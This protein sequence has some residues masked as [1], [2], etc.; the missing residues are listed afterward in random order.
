M[1][2]DEIIIESI[3]SS[4]SMNL[5]CVRV[6]ME[7]K[8]QDERFKRS[9][10]SWQPGEAVISLDREKKTKDEASAFTHDPRHPS[11][12]KLMGFSATTFTDNFLIC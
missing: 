8:R 1:E 4:L 10:S 2:T 6:K 5:L 12:V 3:F 11:N 7:Q 9:D